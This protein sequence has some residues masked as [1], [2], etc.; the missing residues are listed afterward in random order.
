MSVSEAYLDE[1]ITVPAVVTAPVHPEDV[2][3]SVL[4]GTIG[5]SPEGRN[6]TGNVAIT[7]LPQAESAPSET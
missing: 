1:M 5:P 7:L 6:P 4:Q 3:R 2:A